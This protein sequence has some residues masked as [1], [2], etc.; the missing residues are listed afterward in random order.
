MASGVIYGIALAL[1]SLYYGCIFLSLYTTGATEIHVDGFSETLEHT[2]AESCNWQESV[3]VQK[4]WMYEFEQ[5]RVRMASREGNLLKASKITN[6]AARDE[7]L[8]L[9]NEQVRTEP[10]FYIL[11]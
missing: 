5:G 2:G 9:L 7:A 8:E 10:V 3:K 11:N 6:Q 1:G 4:Q